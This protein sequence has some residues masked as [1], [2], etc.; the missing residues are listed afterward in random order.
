MGL[1]AEVRLSLAC[2]A[3]NK[4]M[5]VVVFLAVFEPA[6]CFFFPS[7]YILGNYKLML[8]RIPPRFLFSCYLGDR[9]DVCPFLVY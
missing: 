6:C 3:V 8:S 2:F 9:D 5:F 7:S 4:S 1:E